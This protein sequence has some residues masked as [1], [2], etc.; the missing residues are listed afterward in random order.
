MGSKQVQIIWGMASPKIKIFN[1]SSNWLSFVFFSYFLAL[2]FCLLLLYWVYE[3]QQKIQELTQY[4]TSLKS[5]VI[6]SQITQPITQ[7]ASL[8]DPVHWPLSEFPQEETF[9]EKN[10]SD[11]D[12][13]NIK[14][15]YKE[16][17]FMIN[18]DIIRK[19][20]KESLTGRLC[21]F[22]KDDQGKILASFPE[23]IT[24]FRPCGEGEFFKFKNLRP[25]ILTFSSLP[26]GVSKALVVILTTENFS[27]EYNIP[28]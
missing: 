28:L 10:N 16:K 12:F 5:L 7:Q 23:N 1:F 13:Q 3:S 9:S 25:T 18:F 24:T 26:Q 19:N 6:Q 8:E 15:Q 4:T 21:A 11:I 27:Q 2:F 20:A 22:L 17:D 14:S